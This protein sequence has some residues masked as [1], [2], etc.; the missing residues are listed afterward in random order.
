MEWLV[1]CITC[2]HISSTLL[3]GILCWLDSSKKQ[4][5]KMKWVMQDISWEKCLWRI[6]RRGSTLDGES[7][8]MQTMMQVWLFGKKRQG[9][10]DRII[11]RSDWRTALRKSKSG[12]L[13]VL[14]QRL[15]MAGWSCVG[16]KWPHSITSWE[17]PRRSGVWQCESRGWSQRGCSCRQ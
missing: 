9:K 11:G 16:Q 15:P 5:V 17:E 10:K 14:R 2:A 8:Q 6:K 7:L 12:Q 13:G 1:F 3:D 4:G